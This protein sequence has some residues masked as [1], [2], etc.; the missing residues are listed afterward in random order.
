LSA[1]EARLAALQVGQGL[2]A[3]PSNE[4]AGTAILALFR[5]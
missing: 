1:E 5:E 4:S 2:A 3:A